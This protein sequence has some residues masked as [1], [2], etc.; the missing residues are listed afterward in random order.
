MLDTTRLIR[1]TNDKMKQIH[2]SDKLNVYDNKGI[3]KLT[4]VSPGW[5][6]MHCFSHFTSMQVAKLNVLSD[7]KHGCLHNMY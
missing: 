3:S 2:A 1:D 7:S 4:V 6:A 5:I